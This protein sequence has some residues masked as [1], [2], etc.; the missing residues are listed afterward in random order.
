MAFDLLPPLIFGKSC[1]KFFLENVRKKNN[2][3]VKNL[4]HKFF[5]LK[6]APKEACIAKEKA[7]SLSK[8]RAMARIVHSSLVWRTGG[9]EGLGQSQFPAWQPTRQPP[10][11]PSPLSPCGARRALWFEDSVETSEAF[12]VDVTFDLRN[13]SLSKK[14]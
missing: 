8:L 6:M 13:V 12:E 3:K 11:Q 10:W 14:K 9:I 2:I 1:S 7:P 4:Q 5:G